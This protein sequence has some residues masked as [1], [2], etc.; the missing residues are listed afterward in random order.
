MNKETAIITATR[1]IGGVE[2]EKEW[3]K[4]L[5]DA[6]GTD[7]KGW[8]RKGGASELP[9][10]NNTIVKSD[11]LI[12]DGK[13]YDALDLLQKDNDVKITAEVTSKIKEVEEKIAEEEELKANV[14]KENNENNEGVNFDE[15]IAGN[16]PVKEEIE[17][18]KK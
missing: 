12:K 5:W 17:G 6:L 14:V 4:Y 10:V 3:P 7:K 16:D 2:I 13:L 9:K 8:V 18:K 1:T 15:N 11:G